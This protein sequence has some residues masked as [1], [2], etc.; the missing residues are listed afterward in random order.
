MKTCKCGG[1]IM[2][3]SGKCYACKEPDD[4]ALII[5]LYCIAGIALAW[6]TFAGRLG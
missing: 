4:S 1:K 2:N 6:V 3:R 5:T